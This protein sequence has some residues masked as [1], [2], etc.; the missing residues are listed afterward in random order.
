MLKSEFHSLN[1][2]FQ[3]SFK[4]KIEIQKLDKCFQNLVKSFQ[5]RKSFSYKSQFPKTLA[6]LRDSGDRLEDGGGVGERDTHPALISFEPRP[7]LRKP[8]I[9]ELNY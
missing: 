8:E 6:Y 2:K 5:F 9:K 4:N 3:K 1:P 7:L